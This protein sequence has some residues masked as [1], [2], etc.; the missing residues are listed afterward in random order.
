MPEY[1]KAGL[2]RRRVERRKVAR[3]DEEVGPRRAR[4]G[5][6]HRDGSRHIVEAGLRRGLMADGREELARVAR[7]PAL[8]EA[9]VADMHC[10]VEGLA[11]EMVS[12]GIVKEVRRRR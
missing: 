5:I 11:I 9:A 4:A 2:V 7:D 6:R 1:C 10:P 12:V 8:D 3:Q